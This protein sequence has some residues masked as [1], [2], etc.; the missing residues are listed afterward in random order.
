[1][2]GDIWSWTAFLNALKDLLAFNPYL[3][4]ILIIWIAVHYFTD[5][6]KTWRHENAEKEKLKSPDLPFLHTNEL[7]KRLDNIEN[8]IRD[9][10]KKIK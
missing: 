3:I 9:L 4:W 2:P 7:Y 1:M 5:V 10:I 8:S 6:I